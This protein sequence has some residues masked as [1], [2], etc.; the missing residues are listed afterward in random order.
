MPS[1]NFNN[2]GIDDD[3]VVRNQPGILDNYMK[4]KDPFP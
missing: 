3:A 1:C 4:T 2:F